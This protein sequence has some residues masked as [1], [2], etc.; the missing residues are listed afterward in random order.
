MN[1]ERSQSCGADKLQVSEGASA[2]SLSKSTSAVVL[3]LVTVHGMCA[4]S[5]SQVAHYFYCGM[6]QTS[7]RMHGKLIQK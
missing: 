3:S 5:S 4:L 1:Q 7:P 2:K 6:H